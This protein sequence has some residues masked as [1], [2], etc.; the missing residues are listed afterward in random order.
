MI[1]F[2]I[3][4]VAAALVLVGL[5]IIAGPD[6]PRLWRLARTAAQRV[7]EDVS[8]RSSA[9]PADSRLHGSNPS[10]ERAI[11]CAATAATILRRHRYDDLA[12]RLANASRRLAND[13]PTGLRS[14]L[15]MWPRLQHVRVDDEAGQ[16]MLD[17]LLREMHEAVIDRAE[18][19][20]LL[21]FRS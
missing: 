8:A 9:P 14:I 10:T 20:E 6:L 13:E 1:D 18:Q 5:A 16:A 3:A 11:A 21:P 7:R 4:A 19:L 2:L 15:A 17:R 12:I